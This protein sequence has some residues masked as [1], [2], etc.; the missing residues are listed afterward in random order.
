MNLDP[1]TNAEKNTIENMM[2]QLLY[3]NKPKSPTTEQLR[4]A[5]EKYLGDLGEVPYVE[6]S[7]ESSGDVS[8]SKGCRFV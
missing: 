8:F 3:K 1:N 5:L 7:G 6:P 2:V 4:K